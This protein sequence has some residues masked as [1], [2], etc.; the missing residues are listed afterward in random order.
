MSKS[1]ED[2]TR[3][4]AAGKAIIDG[5]DPNEAPEIMMTL[6]QTVAAVL[7]LLYPDHR[8]AA[9]MLNEGLLEGVERRIS[10]HQ[11]KR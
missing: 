8:M 1:S 9:A 7:L 3:S 4:Y 5:R 11:A 10:M 6:E 2:T